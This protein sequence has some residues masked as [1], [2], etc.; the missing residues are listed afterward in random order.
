VSIGI[1][2][3][4][5][6]LNAFLPR[7]V[8]GQTTTLRDGP[9][10]GKTAIVGPAYYVTDQ[11]GFSSDRRASARMHS[12][13]TVDFTGSTPV[14]AQVHRCDPTIM[15]EP[16][17]DAV[18]RRARSTTSRMRG[19][20]SSV[21]PMVVIRL[22]AVASH[23]FPTLTPVSGDSAYRGDI[24]VDRAA[25]TVRVDLMVQLFPAFEGYASINEGPAAILFHQ[26][27]PPGVTELRLPAAAQ[28][29]IRCALH[30]GDGDGVFDGPIALDIVPRS[31]ERLSGRHDGE[32]QS[33]ES[34]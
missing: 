11:R 29:R 6:W 12:C 30:D 32:R 3:I 20:V 10:A 7:D 4:T 18:P 25:R 5:V 1:D 22:D 14:V 13:V 24:V 17:A 9:C 19:V 16:R 26:A 27:P 8:T 28:R 15:C 34:E 31:P 23:P 21:T 33:Q 2:S